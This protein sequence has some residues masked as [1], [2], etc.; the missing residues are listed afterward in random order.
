[1]KY[2][3]TIPALAILA[4]SSC[5]NEGTK[6][7]DNT[8]Q[9]VSED[10]KPGT[11]MAADSMAV[12]EDELN[13]AFF[14][15]QVV[16]TEHSAH[17]RSYKV[18]AHYGYNEAASEF[19]MPRGGEHLKPVIKKSALAYTYDIGFYYNGEP[20]FYDYYEVSANR[21]EIKMKYKK[22]YSLK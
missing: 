9:T 8:A 22:A 19:T 4:L 12:I 17:Y 15:V 16:A 13:G 3:V 10:I 21:G 18:V 14:A 1:M 5:N 11:L 20:D 2:F 7:T 6:T